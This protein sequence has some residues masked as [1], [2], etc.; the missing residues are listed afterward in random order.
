MP[1]LTDQAGGE[2]SSIDSRLEASRQAWEGSMTRRLEALRASLNGRNLAHLAAL[3]EADLQADALLM[4]YWGR[5]V[6]ISWP[7]LAASFAD[8]GEPC[9]TFD[10]AMLLYYLDA[11]DGTAL[12]DRWIGF[13]D[14]P[15][16][17]FYNQAFQG[18]SGDL[19]A[20]RFG[21]HPQALENAAEALAGFRLPALAPFAFSF[22]PLPRIR[23]AAVLWP[24]DEDFPARASILFDAAC[25][26][27]MT[28]D[29]LALL[30]SG[31][32]RRLLRAAAG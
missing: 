12:A 14:L 7:G 28:T 32:A 16:G 25:G 10:C 24:G 6:R 3:C 29:G 30:G 1:G 22:Q 26:H 17:G 9:T 19:L 8:G 2:T 27:Y 21:E 11:A 5:R 20:H 31:L 4:D 18:Y 13:R 15:D 23:L